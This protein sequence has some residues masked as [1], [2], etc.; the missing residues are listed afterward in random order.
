MASNP[1][2][3]GSWV[4]LP[5]GSEPEYAIE[6]ETAHLLVILT[7]ARAEGYL[8]ELHRWVDNPSSTAEASDGYINHLVNPVCKYSRSGPRGLY[9]GR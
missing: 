1:V 8:A 7:P 5:R 6:S 3:P 4:L 9:H 2:S